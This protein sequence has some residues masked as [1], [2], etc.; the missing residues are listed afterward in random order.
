[1]TVAGRAFDGPLTVHGT[2]A[3]RLANYTVDG[4]LRVAISS[5]ATNASVTMIGAAE[6]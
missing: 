3:V 2:D 5:S 4:A 1:V 6:R